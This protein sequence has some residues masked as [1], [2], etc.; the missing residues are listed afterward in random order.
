MRFRAEAACPGCGRAAWM[1]GSN[2]TSVPSSASRVR[3]PTTSALRARRRASATAR[4][5]TAVMS[6]VPLMRARPS[7]GSRTSGAAPIAPQG[8][9]AGQAASLEHALALADEGEREVGEGR[10]VPARPDRSLRGH[11]GVDAG[12]QQRDQELERLEAH[13]G[14]ALGEHV[15]PQ[16]H[17]RPRLRLLEGSTDAGGVGAEQV[18]LQLPQPIEGDVDVG[19]VAEAGG[20]AVDHGAA[21]HGLVH[22]APGGPDGVARG[23]GQ[24]HRAARSRHRLEGREVERL[25]VDREGRAGGC[26]HGTGTGSL[27]PRSALPPGPAPG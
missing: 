6:W 25:A 8:L 4:P 27:A 1:R 12:V 7:L 11:D 2:A 15:G 19:E 22:H 16:E 17:Q 14:E 9:G 3:A 26:A 18:E 10:Q 24:E 20:H 13:A 5:P 21:R 23:R